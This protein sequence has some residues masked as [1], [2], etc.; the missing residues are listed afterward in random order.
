MRIIT[1]DERLAE[2]HGP[3]LL[4]A[5]ISKIGKTS[6]LRTVNPEATLFVDLE[7]GEQSVRDVPVD[8]V[9]PRTW[10]ECRDLAS[11]LGGPNPALGDDKPYSQAHYNAV[12]ES[13][14]DLHLA[15]YGLYFIDSI[16]EASRLCFAWA[17]EQ[18]E[19][20]NKD[21]KPDPRGTYGLLGREMV[22]WLNQIKHARDKAVVFVCILE[23][24][25]DD[26]GRKSWQLQIMG[27]MAGRELPGIV[28]GVVTM[29]LIDKG[30][31]TPPERFFVCRPDN[32][33]KFPAGVRTI[34]S[35]RLEILEAPDLGALLGK[36]SL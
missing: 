23:E 13:F 21:G 3:K 17:S 19:A 1:A 29:A 9:R 28:D 25:E 5:G 12:V 11:F 34:E 2:R 31:E 15:K 4:I 26:Y 7:S 10:K 8:S 14:A 35:E 18:P 27:G 32:P 36:L 20:Y 22:N 24:R 33:A 6:L 30:D 16:T